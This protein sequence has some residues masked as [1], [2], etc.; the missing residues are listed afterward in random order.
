MHSTALGLDGWLGLSG[1][2]NPRFSR[3][4]AMFWL[5]ATDVDIKHHDWPA[6]QLR[7]LTGAKTHVVFTTVVAANLVGLFCWCV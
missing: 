1:Q 5:I 3:H 2:R 7:P 4:L 6:I